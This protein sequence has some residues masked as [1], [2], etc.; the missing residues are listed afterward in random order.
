[1]INKNI[2]KKSIMT[3]EELGEFYNAQ[4]E[5]M[6]FPWLSDVK[7]W[8]EKRYDVKVM[9]IQYDIINNDIFEFT[10]YLYSSSEW[11]NIPLTDGQAFWCGHCVEIEKNISKYLKCNN[12]IRC[13][14]TY[15]NFESS[16]KKYLLSL[17]YR[18]DMLESEVKS[19][20]IRFKPIYFSLVNP[21]ICVLETKEKARDFLLSEYYKFI[22]KKCFDL[23][24]PYDDYNVLKK[25]D[26]K[27][28]V[29]YKENKELVPMYSRWVQEMPAD[30]FELYEKSIIES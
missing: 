11:K 20:F 7:A 2:L 4:F 5:P 25:D 1:M 17:L 9:T 21:I 23:L 29:D 6:E 27:I 22:K 13:R 30:Q 3:K 28:F 18:L 12:K 10:L 24:K 8:I 16:A 14:L 19:L 15:T 26:I